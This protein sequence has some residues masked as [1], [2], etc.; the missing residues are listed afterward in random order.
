[1]HRRRKRRRSAAKRAFSPRLRP[2]SGAR[3]S[4]RRR[5]ILPPSTPFSIATPL[6][7]SSRSA[8]RWG[9]ASSGAAPRPSRTAPRFMPTAARSGCCSKRR[10]G[11]TL[12]SRRSAPAA[13]TACASTPRA[14]AAAVCGSSA[15]ASN[16]AAGTPRPITSIPAAW[17]TRWSS[18][19]AASA[20]RDATTP[21]CTTTRATPHPAH[22]CP[23]R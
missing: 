10:S 5:R 4:T 16:A 3:T 13:S 22:T 19:P 2:L 18:R 7:F 23:A 1:M 20:V 14:T 17:P 8:A 6:S 12:H 21:I 9:A 11:S 15:R